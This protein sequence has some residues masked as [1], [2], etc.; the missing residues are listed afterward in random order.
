MGIRT[1][2]AGAL[3]LAAAVGDAL[4]QECLRF[5]EALSL[6][7]LNDPNVSI[8]RAELGEAEADLQEAKSLFFPQISA[9]TR[10]GVGDNGLVETQIENQFGLR[11]S[12][13]LIDFGDARFA[14]RASREAV[15][16]REFSVAAAQSGA[17]LSAGEAFLGWLESNAQLDA[18]VEREGFFR[19]QL[20]A[21][22]EALREGGATRA[23]RAEVAAE[24][25]EA[26]ATRLEI[27]FARD[28]FATEIALTTESSVPPCRS[29]DPAAI[30]PYTD[31][32][33]SI[34]D[35]VSEALSVNANIE[36]LRRAVSSLEADAKRESRQRLPIIDVVGVFS[37]AFDDTFQ[38]AEFL[39]RVGVDVQVP[40]YAG[41]SLGAR[42]RQAAARAARAEG[43]LA[44]ALRQLKQDISI[45]YRRILALEAQT[46]RRREVLDRKR[47]QFEAAE[48]EYETGLRTLPDLIDIRLELEDADLQDIRARFSLARERLALSVMTG[49]LRDDFGVSFEAPS[50]D[51]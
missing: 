13:R 46:V 16:A 7:A 43:Q 47:E 44:Q 49:R 42:R 14:R 41:N 25:G 11:A 28:R 12:Q 29:T 36:S 37:Y 20:R 40:L 19:D 23:D 21:L 34:D 48:V 15:K 24:L 50:E 1:L 8:S 5:D 38:D 3:F 39:Q 26:Q 31:D 10:T 32:R 2:A 6:A 17:S 9:F 18:T 22:D 33:V 35:T 51:D 45:T 27:E 30:M 4:G